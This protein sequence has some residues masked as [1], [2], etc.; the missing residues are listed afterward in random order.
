MD[1]RSPSRAGGREEAVRFSLTDPNSIFQSGW[2]V[3][4]KREEKVGGIDFQGAGLIENSF[5][6]P[7]KIWILHGRRVANLA[8]RIF[9]LAG[10]T[11][12]DAW[13]LWLAAANHDCGKFGEVYNKREKLTEKDWEIIR[14]HP[15]IGRLVFGLK[16]CDKLDKQDLIHI[17]SMISYHHERPDGKGYFHYKLTSV[18]VQAIIMADILDAANSYR[19]Y[20]NDRR[21]LLSI[22]MESLRHGFDAD[23]VNSV[24]EVGNSY[25]G[26]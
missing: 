26:E 9:L 11:P 20:Q 15:L 18:P 10:G 7:E 6:Q 4:Y 2:A 16:W 8:C 3:T 5:L 14:F 24:I 19:P 12:K 17:M 21:P 13:K 1:L 25:F 23:L 22:V